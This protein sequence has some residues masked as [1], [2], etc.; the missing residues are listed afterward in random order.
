MIIETTVCTFYISISFDK[1]VEKFDNNEAPSRSAKVI[2]V[3]FRVV[4]KDN[5]KKAI[6][7]VQVLKG[8]LEKHIPENFKVLGKNGA[9]MSTTK[10]SLWFQ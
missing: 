6:A 7:V 9:I 8:V 10:A 5:Q 4:S 3:I 2:K 1:W